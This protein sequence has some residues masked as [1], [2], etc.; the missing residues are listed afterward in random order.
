V[1]AEVWERAVLTGTDI[2]DPETLREALR[3]TGFR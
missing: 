3:P 2:N 1:L